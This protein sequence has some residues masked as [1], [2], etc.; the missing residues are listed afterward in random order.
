MPLRLFIY[1]IARPNIDSVLMEKYYNNPEKMERKSKLL[2]RKQLDKLIE[3]KSNFN[4]WIKIIRSFFAGKH[5]DGL[6][7]R[8]PIYCLLTFCFY[9]Y[10]RL[11]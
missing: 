9:F 4:K 10:C 6:Y 2:S 7:F 3:S 5:V 8:E 11:D 1:N